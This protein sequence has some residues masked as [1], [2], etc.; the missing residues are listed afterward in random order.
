MNT[1]STANLA[2]VAYASVSGVDGSIIDGSGFASSTKI[3][4]GV[5][6]LFLSTSLAQEAVSGTYRD[7]LVVTPGQ[8]NG[9]QNPKS[10]CASMLTSTAVGVV[11]SSSENTDFTIMVLRTVL[12]PT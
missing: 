11:F 12:P 10:V 4:T 3:S 2:L 6:N 8:S 1:F 9:S 7:L 5:T